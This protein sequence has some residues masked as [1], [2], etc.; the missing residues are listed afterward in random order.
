[1]CIGPYNQWAKSSRY[2]Q[3]KADSS[4]DFRRAE[5][6]L[7]AYRSS[8]SQYNYSCALYLPSE[9]HHCL[10]TLFIICSNLNNPCWSWNIAH[11]VRFGYSNR[12]N[13]S[14]KF[15]EVRNDRVVYCWG[16]FNRHWPFVYTC[17]SMYV[18]QDQARSCNCWNCF[19]ICKL[20]VLHVTHASY[21]HNILFRSFSS[22]CHRWFVSLWN[23]SKVNFV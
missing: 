22:Y 5:R 23:R 8:C 1:M 11:F 12:R 19:Y 14:D 9:M 7:C 21:Q 20:E 4:M 13:T 16:C 10:P 2:F 15:S 6:V 18:Q 3:C 17:N